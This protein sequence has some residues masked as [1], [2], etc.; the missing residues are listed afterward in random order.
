MKFLEYTKLSAKQIAKMVRLKQIPIQAPRQAALEGIKYLNPRFGAVLQ[1]YKVPVVYNTSSQGKLAGVPMLAKA[2]AAV[3]G[4]ITSSS[5]HWLRSFIANRT[6]NML[7]PVLKEGAVLLGS[8]K[9]PEFSLM[10]TCSPQRKD[11]PNPSITPARN[12]F[13]ESKTA[14]GSSG[15]AASA[16]SLGLVPIAP[17]KSE[18]EL[19][20][21]NAPPIIEP[22]ACAI[23]V[24]ICVGSIIVPVLHI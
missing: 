13:N 7:T 9:T 2:S 1:Q 12:P 11:D 15:G 6:S 24:S 17:T 5:S 3:E 14:G 10:T 8:T 20:S 19:I 22:A 21:S 18:T 4:Q 16:V 23:H